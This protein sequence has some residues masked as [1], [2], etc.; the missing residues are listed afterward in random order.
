MSFAQE[1]GQ[2]GEN[3]AQSEESSSESS[4]TAEE[5]GWTPPVNALG[6]SDRAGTGDCDPIDAR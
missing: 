2:A 1:E 3:A 5:L 6:F 4:K